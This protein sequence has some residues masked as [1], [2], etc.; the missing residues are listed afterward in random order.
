MKIARSRFDLSH[1]YGE[2]LERVSNAMADME[3]ASR[4]QALHFLTAM[5]RAVAKLKAL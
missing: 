3:L 5:M 1:P 2:L 4:F